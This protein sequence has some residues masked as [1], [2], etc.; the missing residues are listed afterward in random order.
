MLLEPV[1]LDD[2][3]YGLIADDLDQ[4]VH[5]VARMAIGRVELSQIGAAWRLK[6][7]SRKSRKY[8]QT[9]FRNPTFAPGAVSTMFFIRLLPVQLFH[10][11]RVNRI[12]SGSTTLLTQ[13]SA[14]EK[15][16]L[17]WWFTAQR[18]IQLIGSGNLSH[19]NICLSS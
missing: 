6:S 4:K 13:L 16:L 19:P 17:H 5:L 3:R 7:V 12:G 1:V 10:L 14:R 8:A 15:T 2:D 11:D 9:S 18:V